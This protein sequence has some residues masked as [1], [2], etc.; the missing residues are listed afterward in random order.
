[1]NTTLRIGAPLAE[2]RGAVILIHGRGG[3]AEDMAGLA[4]VLGTQEIAYL[5]PEAE[6]GSWYPQRFLAP[7]ATNEPAL[8]HA[9]AVVG[10]LVAEARAAG[11]AWEK[12]ALVGF[13]QGACLA[14]EYATRQPQRYGFVAGLSG[15]LIG[16][17]DVTRARFDLG[18]TPVLVACAERDAHIPLVHVE[19]TAAA[20]AAQGARVTKHVFPGAAHTIFPEEIAWLRKAVDQLR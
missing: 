14:L 7:L 13:S 11:L 10:G 12:I 18:G 6:N 17:L 9:L 1:M 5:V 16:P 15:A 3:S 8:S 20:L 19:H 2:A 4:T